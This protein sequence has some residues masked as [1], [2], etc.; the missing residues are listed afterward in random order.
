MSNLDYAPYDLARRIS[1]PLWFTRILNR[2]VFMMVVLANMCFRGTS[3]MIQGG[4]EA[5]VYWTKRTRM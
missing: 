5:S 3:L 1:Y 2:D 4:N